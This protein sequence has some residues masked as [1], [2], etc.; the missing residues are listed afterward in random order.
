MTW[1]ELNIGDTYIDPRRGQWVVVAQFR[2][3][4]ITRLLYTLSR[5]DRTGLHDQSSD[6]V[7]NLEGPTSLVRGEILIHEDPL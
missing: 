3:T 2:E 4:K 1:S 6:A 5:D 7:V